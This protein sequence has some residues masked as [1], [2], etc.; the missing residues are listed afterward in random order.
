M[1]HFAPPASAQLT[2]ARSLQVI[3]MLGAIM[4]MAILAMSVL[5]RSTT[6]FAS[7]GSTSSSLPGLIEDVARLIHRLAAS[8]VG[9]LALAATALCWRNR[10]ALA[11]AV[12]P[13][14]VIAA[15]TVVLALIGPLTPG[16][17][18][19][20]VTVANVLGGTLLLAA[21]WWL[22][23]TLATRQTR[24]NALRPILKAALI[25][26]F[27]HIT[28]GATTSALEMRGIHGFAVVHQGSAML[29]IIL[30]GA[31]LWDKDRPAHLARL[32]SAMKWLLGAQIALGLTFVLIDGR[33]AWLAV[34]HALFSPLLAAGLVSIAVR[35][36]QNAPAAA[37]PPAQ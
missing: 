5:M 30:L 37:R 26:L 34:V 32:F 28:A 6:V 13:V 18:F 16:Y 11:Q 15:T 12:V 4:A 29:A 3:G 1:V 19:T 21:C 2:P 33:P 7:D 22:R 8:S 35:D 14:V 17:R 9:L 10:R 27:M 31:I 23:E 20:A 36:V 25:V 24:H